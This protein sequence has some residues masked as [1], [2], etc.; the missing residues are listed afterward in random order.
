MTS[1]LDPPSRQQ[2]ESPSAPGWVPPGPSGTPS[3][4]PAPPPTPQPSTA[5]GWTPPGS[6]APPQQSPAGTK[7]RGI[8]KRWIVLGAIVALAGF[9]LFQGWQQQQAYDTG[10]AAY[11]TADCAAAIGPLSRAAGEGSSS[12]DNDVALKARAELQECEA[13]LAAEDLATQG[14]R[15]DALL[16][17]SDIV[18]KYPRS[19]LKEAALAKGQEAITSA[20]DQVATLGVCDA[21][22]TLEAQQFIA[23]PVDSLPPLLYACGQAYEAEKAYAEALAAYARFRSEYPDHDLAADVEAALV[24]ATLAETD[25]SGAGSL[26]A[27]QEQGDGTGTAGVATVVIQ[28]DSPDQLSMVFSGPDVRVEDLEACADCVEFTGD[29]PHECQGLGP[30]GEYKLGPGTY[31]VV[32][33]SGSGSSVIPFR[34]TWDLKAGQEYASCFYIVSGQ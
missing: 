10:H 7:P 15:G 23:S 14:V 27:P 11:L 8:R 30:I 4:P 21:L 20:P 33:K 29:G 22:D 24:R 25:A 5:Q 31:D 17:Y 2:P 12:T 3:L 18:T 32:V 19:P 16:A 9:V 6:S 1:D 28:N 13:L 26:P 34:G